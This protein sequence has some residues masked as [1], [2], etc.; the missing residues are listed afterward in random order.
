MIK[1]YL[2]FILIAHVEFIGNDFSF[3]FT[4]FFHHFVMYFLL[5]FVI[6]QAIYFL[7]WFDFLS[8]TK[9]KYY[10]LFYQNDVLLI[11]FQSFSIY[12]DW[13]LSITIYNYAA[14]VNDDVVFVLSIVQY[15]F[16]F[17][18]QWAWTKNLSN[19]NNDKIFTSQNDF[20]FF[21][22]SFA[23][24]SFLFTIVRFPFFIFY[25][26]LWKRS[27]KSSV[28]FLLLISFTSTTIAVVWMS[29]VHAVETHIFVS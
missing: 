1:Y 5:L 29:S 11:W 15:C 26:S 27:F 17:L 8:S 18:S 19:K 6:H 25:I 2:G 7:I 4:S 10:F 22:S 23:F 16:F 28:F 24:S 12:A 9:W 20:F 14:H 3:I 21:T 13:I